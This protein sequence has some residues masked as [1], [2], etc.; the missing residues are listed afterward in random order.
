VPVHSSAISKSSGIAPE[1]PGDEY[2]TPEARALCARVNHK[3]ELTDDE[4]LMLALAAAQAALAR[5]FHPGTRSAEEALE[6]IGAIVDHEDLVAALQRKLR[7]DGEK[8]KA[9]RTRMDR[10][11]SAS[12]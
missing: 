3:S 9:F 12:E 8:E 5:Y 6:S 4:T 1:V 11:D 7:I 2:F 10:P